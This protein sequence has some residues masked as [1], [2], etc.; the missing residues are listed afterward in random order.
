MLMLL[1]DTALLQTQQLFKLSPP[2][3]KHLEFLMG[4]LRGPRE[5]NCF[6]KGSE[7]FTWDDTADFVTLHDPQGEQD[8]FSIWLTSTAVAFYHRIW[9]RQR[10]VGNTLKRSLFSKTCI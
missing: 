9:G 3:P 4:W 6:L 10:Q 1:L 8:P 2:S 5:E 7:V